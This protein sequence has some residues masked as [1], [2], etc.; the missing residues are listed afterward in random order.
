MED[1]MR[2]QTTATADSGYYAA[3]EGGARSRSARGVA[4][5]ASLPRRAQ[6]RRTLAI[7]L[8]RRCGAG[9][10]A[11]A[12]GGVLALVA[13]AGS[14]RAQSTNGTVNFCNNSSNLLVFLPDSTPVTASNNIKAALY[15]APVGSNRFVMLGAASTV[16]VPRPGIFAG[17]TR[18]AGPGTAGGAVGQFQVRAWGGPYT[19]YEQGFT[20][21]GYRSGVSAII[22]MPTG[23]P[24]NAAPTPP[25]SLVAGGFQ[26]FALGQS[27]VIIVQPTNQDIRIGG[28][29]VFAVTATGATP[30]SYQWQFNGTNL[31]DSTHL[32]GTRTDTLAILNVQANDAG[33]YRVIVTNLYGVAISSNA[34]LS[35]VRLCVPPP[36]GLI[37][38]WKGDGNGFDAA[39]GNNAYAMPNISFTPGIVGQ[40][41]ACDPEN[42]TWGTYSGI[43]VADQPAYALTNSL[44]IEGWIRPRGDGYCIFLRGDNRSGLDPYALSMQLNN[45]IAFGITDANGN[46]ASVQA[47]LVYSQWWHVAGTLDG[48]S[49]KLSLYTNGTLAAQI[50]T[51]I[52]PFGALIPTDYP[53]IGI[54][55]VN[56]NFNNFPFWGDIDEISLYNRALTAAEV[57]GLYNAYNSGKCLMCAPVIVVPPT[58]QIV[59]RGS[60]AVFTVLAAGSPTLGYQWSFNG[61][62]LTD[63]THITG[64]LTP[65]LTILNVQPGDAGNYRVTVTNLYGVAVSSNAVLTVIPTCMKPPPGLIGWWKGEGNGLDSAGPNDGVLLNGAAFASGMVGQAFSLNGNSQCVQIPYSPSLVTS[66]YSVEAWIKP[67]AQVSDPISQDLIFGQSYGHCQLVARTGGAGVGIAFQFATSSTTFYKVL[68]TTEM[69]IGQFSHLVGTWDGTVLGLYVNGVLNAQSTPGASPVDPGCPFFIGGFYSPAAGSCS[70]VGQFFNGLIDEVSWFNRALSATEIQDLYNDN[71]A[72]KCL[73]SPPIIIVPPTNQI[74]VQGSNAVFSVL[75]AGSPTLG[76]Q[77]RFNGSNALAA[78]T[79]TLTIANAQLTNV[80]SYQVM[81]TNNYGSATSAVATLTVVWPPQIIVQLTNQAVFVSSNATFAATATGTAPLAYQWWFNGTN[82]LTST[83][84][85]LTL[86]NVQLMNAGGYHVVVTNNYGRATS[87]VAR[88]SVAL[89]PLFQSVS[90][91]NGTL[92]MTWNG[93]TGFT[94]LLQYKTN[95]AQLYW[96]N[97]SS[98]IFA[99]NNLV[100]GYD[101]LSP[102]R[103]RFYRVTLVP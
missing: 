28:T 31:T 23:N 16:G 75:A 95:L 48:A 9:I 67:L 76:Y 42:L 103:Q 29:T 3:L 21:G 77:W 79:S 69:P 72:G 58:N 101:A 66:N 1:V 18:V 83:S 62:N 30:L 70:Y 38:W 12:L 93:A 80:G 37:G 22:T 96:S 25:A 51:T 34:V 61:T 15:W 10:P 44:T 102:D 54:G 71:T 53:G 82:A 59:L 40:V 50:T 7:R 99:T 55:N 49:G 5:P 87:L 13:L 2:A 64:S 92:T 8:L 11:L 84:A 65:A 78:T 33:T 88:L 89:P 97:S 43:R 52:R 81:V 47:P 57:Q 100:T 60:N 56:D 46:Y 86:T 4:V 39:A 63:G 36:A 32:T 98:P 90:V 68:S 85:T 94:Y 14:A 45:F 27:P 20:N 74:V 24:T 35:Q 17:G 26:G 73:A 91:R 19:N 6:A 41:F